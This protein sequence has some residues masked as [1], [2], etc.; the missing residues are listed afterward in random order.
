MG[1]LSKGMTIAG[2]AAG[3]AVLSQAPEYA[4]QYR[5]RLGGAVDELRVVVTDFDRDA[6]NSQLTRQQAL[7]EMQGS[8]TRF[9]RDRGISM[10][11]TIRRFE[12]LSEQRRLMGQTLPLA[13]PL[14][15]LR[16]P[17]SEIAN[18]AWQ[19]FEP[20]VPLNGPGVV[21]GGLGALI[22]LLFTRFV[23][24]AGRRLR[25]DGKIRV[26]PWTSDRVSR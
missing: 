15:I 23:I 17:D 21:Y 25:G 20:A 3:L 16:N 4:Q 12:N 6:H 24:A 5:Q 10:D 1:L 14:F 7:D 11:R 22:A 18:R 9:A 26:E 8:P 19:D 13:R 2:A